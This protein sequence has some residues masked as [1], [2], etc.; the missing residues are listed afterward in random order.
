M[1]KNR[2]NQ[3]QYRGR[4]LTRSDEP[5]QASSYFFWEELS[6]I[7]RRSYLPASYSTQSYCKP[8]LSFFLSVSGAVRSPEACEDLSLKVH[9]CNGII[10]CGR[11]PLSKLI[12]VADHPRHNCLPCQYIFWADGMFAKIRRKRTRNV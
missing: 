4:T 9:M 7:S 6:Q 10:S 1:N 8:P 5:K 11:R 12:N 3:S 2:I